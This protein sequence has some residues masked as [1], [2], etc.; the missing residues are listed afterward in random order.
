MKSNK[1]ILGLLSCTFAGE[2]RYWD[3][4]EYS[5]ATNSFSEFYKLKLDLNQDDCVVFNGVIPVRDI[6]IYLRLSIYTNCLCIVSWYSSN[7][8]I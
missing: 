1:T 8:Q 5:Q 6:H 3:S 2:I 4:I 7:N